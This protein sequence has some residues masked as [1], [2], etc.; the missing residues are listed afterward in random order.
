LRAGC[1]ARNDQQPAIE[2]SD[3]GAVEDALALCG[4]DGK[5]TSI[6]HRE[7]VGRLRGRESGTLHCG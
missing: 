7:H 6:E 3:V 1:A 4:G 2:L 5:A